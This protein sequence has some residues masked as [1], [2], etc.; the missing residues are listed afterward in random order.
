MPSYVRG[1]RARLMELKT[2]RH[3]FPKCRAALPAN[4]LADPMTTLYTMVAAIHV[5][6]TV[7]LFYT[8]QWRCIS[9]HRTQP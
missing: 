2:Y 6:Q 3:P 5:P 7:C 4:S 9:M 8:N 1:P